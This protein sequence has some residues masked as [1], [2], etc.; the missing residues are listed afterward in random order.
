MKNAIS[1][2]LRNF[3]TLS[4]QNEILGSI[5]SNLKYLSEIMSPSKSISNSLLDLSNL[6][7]KDNAGI[8]FPA[9]KQQALQIL[10]QAGN[11]LIATDKITSMISLIKYNLSRFSD[12]PNLLTQSFNSILSNMTS[13]SMKQKFTDAFEKFIEGSSIPYPTKDALL[14]GNNN[15]INSDKLTHEIALSLT[16]RK[17]PDAEALNNS[18]IIKLIKQLGENDTL[19]VTEG[20]SKIRQLLEM[21]IPSDKS[22]QL[23]Q[24]LSS[25]EQ[26][27]DLNSLINRIRCIINSVSD[28]GSKELLA[29]NLNKILTS[30]SNSSEVIYQKPTTLATLVDFMAKSLGNENIKY[31]GM[32]DP[33]TLIQNMLTAPGVFTPLMHYVLPVQIEDLRAF[34]ELWVDKDADDSSGGE[35]K[36][37]HMFL[38]FDI[39]NVGLFELEI[40]NHNKDLNVSLFCPKEFVKPLSVIKSSI[41]NIAFSKGYKISNTKIDALIVPRTLTQVFPE[42]AERRSGL[43]VKI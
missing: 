43:N 39:E 28:I 17:I 18:D 14:E 7:S 20:T 37:N 19:N 36:D 5:S 32:V 31:L 12:N 42:I 6:F 29:E 2:F 10:E 21:I 25:F 30:L 24:I 1:S 26:T 8:N 41:Q 38:S 9:L 3:S 27:K 40:T 16:N 4:S 15:Y 22:H 33:N 11:S 35:G 34:G 13:E 23:N